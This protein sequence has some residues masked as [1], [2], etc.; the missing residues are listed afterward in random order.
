MVRK[1]AIRIILAIIVLSLLGTLQRPSRAAKRS[2]DPLATKRWSK[3]KAW[4]WYDKIGPMRGCNYLP[5]TAVNS[6]EM[7]QAE[8]FDANTIDQELGWAHDAGYNN[9][10]VFLQY[11]DWKAEPKKFK[12]RV[13]KFLAIAAKNE[14]HRWSFV[15]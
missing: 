7:W 3:E 5:R 1:P 4:A 14:N 2:G 9:I 6:T 10:R 15:L 12:K 11:I 8:T 13:D